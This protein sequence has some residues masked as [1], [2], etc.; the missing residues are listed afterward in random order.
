MSK[1]IISTEVPKPSRYV[2]HSR[3]DEIAM[4]VSKAYRRSM[5]GKA[6]DILDIEALI[7]VVLEKPLIWDVIAEPSNR[8]CFASIDHERI[9]INANHR[10]LFDSKP[11]LLRSCLSHEVGHAILGH[12]S[13]MWTNEKQTSLFDNAPESNYVFHDSVWRQFGLTR[14]EILEVKNDLARTAWR[15]EQDRETLKMLTDRLEPE[16]MFFQ[17]EQFASCLLIPKDQL[18]AWLENG[19][20]ITKWSTLYNLRDFFGVSISMICVRL[21]K[22]GLIEINDKQI[23]LV[24]KPSNKL[25]FFEPEI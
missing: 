7:T 17:A 2:S 12:L 10:G 23:N 4:E 21:E 24:D 11:F 13:L 6:L 14:Q 1:L 9:T 20:D 3:V 18:L 22:L 8:I 15:N 19:G 5:G 16:W 25:N